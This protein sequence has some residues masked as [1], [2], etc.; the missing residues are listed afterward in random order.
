MRPRRY[1]LSPDKELLV[2]QF[3]KLSPN[4]RLRYAFNVA[5]F[6]IRLN[7]QLLLI[8]QRLTETDRP[9]QAR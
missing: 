2:E 5:S 7:P 6:A 3:M 1:I 4:E 8:R 9:G